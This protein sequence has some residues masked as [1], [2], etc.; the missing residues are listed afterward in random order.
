MKC[1]NYCRIGPYNIGLCE[2][3]ID[4]AHVLPPIRPA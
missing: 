3:G 4:P 2:L 1:L